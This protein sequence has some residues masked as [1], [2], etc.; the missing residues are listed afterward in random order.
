MHDSTPCAVNWCVARTTGA[1]RGN[2]SS[3]PHTRSTP[4]TPVDSP[5]QPPP[6]QPNRQLKPPTTGRTMHPTNQPNDSIRSPN[7][8][9]PPSWRE[10]ASQGAK[11]CRD[12][13]VSSARGVDTRRYQSRNACRRVELPGGQHTELLARRFRMCRPRTWSI[14]ETPLQRR[15]TVTATVPPGG[16]PVGWHAWRVSS[17]GAVDTQMGAAGGI[18]ACDGARGRH[19][20]ASP[21]TPR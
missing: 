17:P 19:A 2:Q 21:G 14:R 5:N 3:R 4:P 20:L 6:A 13:G 8:A 11:S 9:A 7:R 12:P 18:R 16:F 1:L 15:N 10:S